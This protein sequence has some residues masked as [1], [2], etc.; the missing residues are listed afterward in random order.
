MI[1]VTLQ[2]LWSRDA[3]TDQQNRQMEDRKSIDG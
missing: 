2:R 3:D 1:M